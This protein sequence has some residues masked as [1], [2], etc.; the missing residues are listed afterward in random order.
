VT[1]ELVRAKEFG[2]STNQV[3]VDVLVLAVVSGGVIICNETVS[4]Y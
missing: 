1:P 4:W 3:S 2:M